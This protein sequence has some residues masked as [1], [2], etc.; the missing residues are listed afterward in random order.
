MRSIIVG[1]IKKNIRKCRAEAPLSAWLRRSH[2]IGGANAPPIQDELPYKAF[3]GSPLSAK[4]KISKKM[5]F[6]LDF[7]I[8]SSPFRTRLRV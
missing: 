6:Y 1:T 5:S 4:A 8:V 3:A 7:K 2:K